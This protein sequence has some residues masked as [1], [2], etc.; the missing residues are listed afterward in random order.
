M[1]ITLRILDIFSLR[2]ENLTKIKEVKNMKN[3][4]VTLLTI[5]LFVA[6]IFLL[7][8][9]FV[10]AIDPYQ[11]RVKTNKME[12][13]KAL[14]S[15]IP[16]NANSIAAGKALYTGK[17]MCQYCHGSF[18]KGDGLAGAAFNPRPRDFTDANW[19]EIRTDGEIFWA[20]TEGTE[21]G[22]IP[23]GD[24]LSEEERWQ[25]VSYIRDLGRQILEASTIAK[26]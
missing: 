14:V 23:F 21:Y 10:H 16:A 25:L 13:A 7:N 2:K 19:Q 4:K 3:Y 22:M 17:G 20:I 8:V 5:L 11:P 1:M 24:I 12:V 18:G 26:E 9:A 15:P 6:T